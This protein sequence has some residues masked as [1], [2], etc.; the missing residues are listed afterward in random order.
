M[1]TVI[2]VNSNTYIFINNDSLLTVL[3]DC[4][5]K[6]CYIDL[7]KDAEAASCWS[8]PSSSGHYWL[9]HLKPSRRDCSHTD[10][11]QERKY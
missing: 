3:S 4:L 11:A 7:Y 6:Y 8:F 1:E 9:L 10:S 5:D 2:S